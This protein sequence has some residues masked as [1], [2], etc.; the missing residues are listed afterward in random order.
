MSRLAARLGPL[1]EKSP[2]ERGREA[3]LRGEA[4]PPFATPDTSWSD[5][6]FSRGWA[7]GI[8]M[9]EEQRPGVVAAVYDSK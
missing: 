2:Y 5:R 9:R 8:E 3:G 1:P 6:L 4:A 7:R